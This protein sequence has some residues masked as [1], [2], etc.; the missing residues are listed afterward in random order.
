MNKG[1]Q[2]SSNQNFGLTKNPFQKVVRQIAGQDLAHVNEEK[3]SGNFNKKNSKPGKNLRLKVS[4][5]KNSKF[6]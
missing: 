3:L 2:T 4:P 1:N 6:S 5:I